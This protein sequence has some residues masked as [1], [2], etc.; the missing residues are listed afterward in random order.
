MPLRDIL[1]FCLV[2]SSLP[3]I[4]YRPYFGILLWTWISLMNPHRLSWGPAY[5]FP[6]AKVVGGVT[7]LSAF[8]SCAPK[9]LPLTREA[10]FLALFAL[11]TVPTTVFALEQDVAWQQFDKVVK[12]QLIVFLTMVLITSRKHLEAF[13]WLIAISVGFYGIKGGLFTIRNGGVSHVNGP[14]ESFIAGNN[15]LGLP[16]VMVIPLMR[17]LQ[18]EESSKR[19]VHAG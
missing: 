18:I 19:Y 17:Y 7:I 2:F 13:I 6:F 14:P 16:L 15:H 12:V 11:W 5:E 3:F 1:L 10:L 9:R 4:L 8:F